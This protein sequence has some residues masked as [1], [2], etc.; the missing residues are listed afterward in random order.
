M[1]SV[2]SFP[3]AQAVSAAPVTFA[4]NGTVTFVA[5][6]DPANPFPV[7]PVAGTPFS[8]TYT[9]D[10]VSPDL[11]PADPS[12]GSYASSGGVFGLTLELGGL[13]FSFS[14]VDIGV[15]DGYTSY[16]AGDQYLVG[17]AAPSTVLSLRF[18]DVSGSLFAGDALPLMPFALDALFTEL[19]FSSLVDDN[20]VDLGGTITALTC[21]GCGSVPEPAS[22]ILMGIMAAAVLTHHRRR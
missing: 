1:A 12:T 5:A 22:M 9:F 3:S 16:G 17:F 11:V 4:F 18:T 7:E 21:E 15:T 6:L 2:L 8:G 13:S 10:P 14:S 20:Q 19:S